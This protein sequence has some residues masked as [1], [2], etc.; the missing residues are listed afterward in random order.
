MT[1]SPPLGTGTIT[2]GDLN[3]S[4]AEVLDRVDAGEHLTVTRHGLVV[5]LL[6]PAT[7]H[8]LAGLVAAGL[9]APAERT[10]GFA[11]QPHRSSP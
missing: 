11:T 7:E 5:A 3:R 10:S 4:T 2:A 1:T 8:P 6:S 9:L